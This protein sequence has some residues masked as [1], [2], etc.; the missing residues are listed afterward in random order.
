M[1]GLSFDDK[2]IHAYTKP[3]LGLVTSSLKRKLFSFGNMCE[4]TYEK[5]T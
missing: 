1:S 2:N 5:I 3:S 4:M